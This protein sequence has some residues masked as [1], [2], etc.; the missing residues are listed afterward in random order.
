MVKYLQRSS[1]KWNGYLGTVV[2]DVTRILLIAPRLHATVESLPLVASA[3]KGGLPLALVQVAVTVFNL[4]LGGGS[5]A[6]CWGVA[7]Y[8]GLLTDRGLLND[9]W[10]DDRGRLDDSG[11]LRGASRCQ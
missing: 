7:Q 2:P 6:N 11:L 8:G 4:I 3:S 9:W 1:L 5:V 10:L